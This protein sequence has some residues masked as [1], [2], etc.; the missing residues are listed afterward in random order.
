MV[1]SR[2]AQ[3]PK[4]LPFSKPGEEPGDAAQL[5]RSARRGAA[6]RLGRPDDAFDEFDLKWWDTHQNWVKAARQ[7]MQRAKDGL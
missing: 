5:A 4:L 1:Q 2:R 7:A 6:A 3:Q